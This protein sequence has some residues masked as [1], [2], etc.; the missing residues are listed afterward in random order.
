M[1]NG[2]REHKAL[3]SY[4]VDSQIFGHNK[5]NNRLISGPNFLQI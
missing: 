5:T 4:I 3:T 2:K 1:V